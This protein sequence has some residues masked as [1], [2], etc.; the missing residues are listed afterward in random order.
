LYWAVLISSVAAF[1]FLA[2]VGTGIAQLYSESFFSSDYKS[3]SIAIEFFRVLLLILLATQVFIARAISS[4]LS[5][6]HK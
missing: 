5:S 3:M 4:S 1:I 2:V 6:I